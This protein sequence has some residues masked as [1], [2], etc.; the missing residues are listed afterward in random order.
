VCVSF[1]VSLYV[2][3]FDCVLCSVQSCAAKAFLFPSGVGHRVLLTTRVAVGR[4]V[5]ARALVCRQ[6][7]F[8]WRK[9][10]EKLTGVAVVAD[11]EA[12]A[13]KDE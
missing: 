10:M 13:V 3:R 11:D 6:E 5:L 12:K 8:S 9:C 7:D 4:V 2:C 1:S